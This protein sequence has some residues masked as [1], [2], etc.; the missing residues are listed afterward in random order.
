MTDCDLLHRVLYYGLLDIRSQGREHNDKAV[1][2]LADLFHNHILQ[3]RDAAI[4]TREYSEVLSDL[5]KTAETTGCQ[6]WLNNAI[7]QIQNSHDDEDPGISR[8]SR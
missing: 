8:I 1:F 3:L 2:R 6:D 4:G 5:M 7:S